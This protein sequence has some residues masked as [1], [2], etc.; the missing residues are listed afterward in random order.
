MLTD[1]NCAGL[2]IIMFVILGRLSA[3]TM[4]VAGIIKDCLLI[5]LSVV[6]TG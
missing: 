1:D 3:V 5:Y 2:N 4:N 6:L